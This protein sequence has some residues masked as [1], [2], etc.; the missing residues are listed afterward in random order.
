MNKVSLGLCLILGSLMCGVAGAK[1]APLPTPKPN[2][3]IKH[4]VVLMQQNR[5]FD[6]YFGTYPGADGIP[7]DVCLPFSTTKPEADA[8]VKPYYLGDGQSADLSHTST[9][10]WRQ[11]NGG[12]MNGFVHALR[13]R[14]Q[15]GALSMGHYDDREL[16]YYWNLADEFVLFD[17][18]FS[19][20]HTGSLWNRTFWVAGQALG[21]ENRIPKA[22]F[23][24]V[25]TIFDRLEAKGISWK[26]YINNYNPQ[27]NYRMLQNS[28]FLHPQV[29]WVPLLSFD[30]FIDDPKLSSHIVDMSEYFKDLNNG[31]LPAVSYMLALGATEQPPAQPEPG[32]RFVRKT[33]QALIQSKAWRSSAFVLTY[34]DWGGW[35]DHVLPP[36]VD[37]YGYGFRVPA[38]LVSPYAKRGYIDSTTLDFT[39]ILKFIEQNY[40][41]EPLATRDAQANSLDSAFDFTQA[42]RAAEFFSFSRAESKTRPKP[43]IGMIY[44]TY[45]TGIGLALAVFL[46]AAVRARPDARRNLRNRPLGLR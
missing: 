35:Y 42:P 9:I 4:L 37:A 34:D 33:L 1:A 30:R 8:C 39:S 25:P 46:F 19:S 6:H 44:A 12:A 10:F 2:T 15:D 23:G 41:L 40:D 31:T 29:Q 28:P 43:R 32:Q 5:T 21:E 26:F 13:L 18:F 17:R 7:S 16:P 3:P 45:G 38:L 14:K 24:D 27:L 11:F 20:A 22:G 36:Q